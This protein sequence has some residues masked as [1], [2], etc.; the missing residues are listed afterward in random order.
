MSRQAGKPNCLSF[1]WTKSTLVAVQY[2]K[3]VIILTLQGEG[4]LS[5]YREAAKKLLRNKS[6]GLVHVYGGSNV[7][8]A[9]LPRS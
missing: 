7:K 2:L 8:K 4:T 9:F 1:N 6:Y 5:N 3:D